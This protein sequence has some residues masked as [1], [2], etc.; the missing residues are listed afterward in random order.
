MR[1]I[2]L[3]L[4]SLFLLT[5]CTVQQQRDVL[6]AIGTVIPGSSTSRLPSFSSSA[7]S[8]DPGPSAARPPSPARLPS[9]APPPPSVAVA[10]PPNPAAPPVAK[11]EAAWVLQTLQR[12]MTVAPA[13]FQDCLADSPCQQALSAHLRQLQDRAKATLELPAVYDQ[14]DLQPNP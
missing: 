4:G 11:T 3:W 9:P 12:A 2:C 7:S 1:Y 10:P 5:S 8:T 13:P 14:Y 6:G